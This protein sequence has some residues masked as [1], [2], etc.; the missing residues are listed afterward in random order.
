MS[1][2]FPGSPTY[3]E[4]EV[5]DVETIAFGGFPIASFRMKPKDHG[6]GVEPLI[7]DD[8]FIETV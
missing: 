7:D 5:L 1:E 2:V 8:V 6:E 3:S 4:A